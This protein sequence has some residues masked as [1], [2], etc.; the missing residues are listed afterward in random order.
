MLYIVLRTLNNCL[1]SS[2]ILIKEH[3]YP[4]N[5]A[6]R[7]WN[8]PYNPEHLTGVIFGV[9]T[10]E[11]DKK[12]ILESLKKVDKERIDYYQVVYEEELMELS[13]RRKMYLRLRD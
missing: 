7:R 12:R 9:R 11:Y 2:I 3:M 1:Y 4:K 10:S 6:N 5:D 8:L 13:V